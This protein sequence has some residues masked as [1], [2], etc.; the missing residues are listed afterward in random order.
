M[1][2][3]SI[4]YFDINMKKDEGG[5]EVESDSKIIK[6]VKTCYSGRIKFSPLSYLVFMLAFGKYVFVL[7]LVAV[8]YCDPGFWV[9]IFAGW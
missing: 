1:A 2:E 3:S 8:V 9:L 4:L 7:L 5:R 6:V